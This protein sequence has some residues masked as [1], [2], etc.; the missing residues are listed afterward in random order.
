MRNL[1]PK[2]WLLWSM[3]LWQ[4][5]RSEFGLFHVFQIKAQHSFF[6][7]EGKTEPSPNPLYPWM[8]APSLGNWRIKCRCLTVIHSVCGFCPSSRPLRRKTCWSRTPVL[9][10]ECMHLHLGTVSGWGAEPWERALPG[11]SLLCQVP[12]TTVLIWNPVPCFLKCK[13]Q[14]PSSEN[15]VQ[16]VE[17]SPTDLPF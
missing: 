13:F 12:K 11:G 7:G 16:W 9:W 10:G 14:T 6:R 3:S 8:C 5:W 15:L 2:W 17:W 4:A 1:D